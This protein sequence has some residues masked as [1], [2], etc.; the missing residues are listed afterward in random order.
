MN[1]LI[2]PGTLIRGG[3]LV[4]KRRA[5]R[6]LVQSS[7]I[8]SDLLDD[9]GTTVLGVNI[10][11]YLGKDEVGMVITRL[12]RPKMHGLLLV[13]SRHGLGWTREDWIRR[14]GTR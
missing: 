8:V 10:I 3:A 6:D 12:H 7:A 1:T 13:L 11:G 14:A 2:K 9:E 4:R 5:G